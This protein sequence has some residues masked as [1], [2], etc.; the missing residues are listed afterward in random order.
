MKKKSD[1]YFD[2]NWRIRHIHNLV[3][4]LAKSFFPDASIEDIENNIDT[5]YLNLIKDD[6]KNIAGLINY[7]ITECD[8]GNIKNKPLIIF[9]DD[10]VFGDNSSSLFFAIYLYLHRSY[11][12]IFIGFS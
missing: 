6:V 4:N 7:F 12:P 10:K 1:Y 11:E 3:D 8:F 2:D 5:P 9:Q